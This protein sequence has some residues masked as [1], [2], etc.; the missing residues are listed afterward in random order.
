MS[1]AAADD[2]N[3][4]AAL[5]RA[6]AERVDPPLEVSMTRAS[7]DEALEAYFADHDT[8]GMDADARGPALF[9]VTAEGRDLAGAA[10]DSTTRPATTTGSSRQSWTSTPP[11]RLGEAV[12]LTTAMRRL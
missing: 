9:E 7:W 8:I 5:E 12:V 6:A 4:L 3:G 2:V 11:T 10:D 1:L